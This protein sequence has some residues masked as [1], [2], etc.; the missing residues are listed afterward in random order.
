MRHLKSGMEET[1]GA[2]IIA[3]AILDRDYRSDGECAAIAASCEDF[4]KYV[5][6]HKRKEIENFLLVPDS[7]DRALRKRITD[8]ARRSGGSS[9]YKP[10]AQIILD[11]FCQAKKTYVASQYLAERRK[12]SRIQS[13]QLHEAS[14]SELALNEFEAKWGTPGV[15]LELVPGK[16]ALSAVNKYAQ[17][18]D[19]VSVTPASIIDA[20][21][22]NEVPFEVVKLIDLLAEFSKEL[23]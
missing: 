22:P 18:S 19:G 23:P 8:R 6:I 12:F 10:F 4:C 3:T 5:L 2:R 21:L 1:L 7:I 11:S 14:V 9:S 20:M 16:E 15:S 13:P 17:E